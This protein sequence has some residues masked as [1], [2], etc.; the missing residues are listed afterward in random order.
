LYMMPWASSGNSQSV[1]PA[2]K[3]EKGSRL[4]L[5]KRWGKP[6]AAS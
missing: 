6:P 2:Q 3:S 4:L 1:L 5:P